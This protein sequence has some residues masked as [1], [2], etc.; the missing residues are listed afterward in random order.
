MAGCYQASTCTEQLT[1][2]AFPVSTAP[3]A[4]ALKGLSTPH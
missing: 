1:V 2:V 4:A 3:Q